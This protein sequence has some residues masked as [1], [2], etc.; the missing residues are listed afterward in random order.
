M[1]DDLFASRRT[2]K[3][4][5]ETAAPVMTQAEK[6]R[7]FALTSYQRHIEELQPH[8]SI[9][10]VPKGE[11]SFEWHLTPSEGLWKG[12]TY[13]FEVVLPNDF[14]YSSPSV[15]LKT[16]IWHP[17]IDTDGKPCVSVLQKGWVPTHMLSY[18]MYGLLYL[19]D[20]PNPDDPLN[21]RA[22]EQ[23]RTDNELFKKTVAEYLAKAK[24]SR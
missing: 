22:A 18:V 17:N 23:M 19:F 4:K 14:P 21:I 3:G 5:T 9:V 20:H 10:L 12:V 13:V 8:E 6:E 16:P 11:L 24:K 15:T 7:A 2:R 1:A